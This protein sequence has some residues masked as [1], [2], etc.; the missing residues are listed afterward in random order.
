MTSESRPE[1][2][3]ESCDSWGRIFQTEEQPCRGPEV[4]AS[5]NFQG[6]ARACVPGVR[7]STGSGSGGR[8]ARGQSEHVGFSSK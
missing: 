4:G 2:G 1:G 6:A 8:G 3:L 5:G 7:I